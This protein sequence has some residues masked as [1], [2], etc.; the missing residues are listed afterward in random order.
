VA[1]F[2]GT[3]IKFAPNFFSTILAP[4]TENDITIASLNMLSLSLTSQISALQTRIDSLDK[5]ARNSV[6]LNQR[7]RALSSLRAKKLAE[8]TIQRR[9]ASLAQVDGV[10]SSI[11]EAAGQ[12]EMVRAM[13][14]SGKVLR[15]LNAA[16]GG[17]EKVETVM[18]IVRKGMADVEDVSRVFAEESSGGAIDEAEVDEELEML[19]R[20]QK[21]KEE[22]REASELPSVPSGVPVARERQREQEDVEKRLSAMSL[23]E[24]YLEKA[25]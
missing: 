3:T 12:V 16:V 5:A 21:E 2:S 19:E 4:V 10:L 6:S 9:E 11:D 8:T 17:V 23:D 14:A 20:A 15:D 24:M 25:A 7:A 13:E 1:S 18:N 22:E